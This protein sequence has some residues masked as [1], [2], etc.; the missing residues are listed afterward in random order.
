ML[1]RNCKINLWVTV[2][3]LITILAGP[4]QAQVEPDRSGLGQAEFRLSELD[5]DNEFRLPANLPDKAGPDAVNDLNVLGLSANAG[6]V[7]IR[8]GRWATLMMAEPLLP[9]SGKGNSL[10]WKNLGRKAPKNEAEL[11]REASQA[12]RG[13]IEAASDEFRIDVAELANPGKVTIHGDG[14]SIQIYV[15]R[16]FN[17]IPVRNSY[18]TATI[19]NG[20]MTIF[21]ANSWG[22]INISTVPTVSESDALEAVQSHAGSYTITGAWRSSELTLIPVAKG[23]NT[24]L[25]GVGD[26]YEYR[27]AWIIRPDFDGEMRHFE[28]LVDA[29]NGELLS[30]V[31]TNQYV[32]SQREVKGGVQPVSNDGV[33]P[34]GVEQAGWPMPFDSVSTPG[35]TVDTDSGGNLP[36]P[37]D[38][39]IT[40]SLSGP[41]V[42]INDNCGAISLTSTGD[43][44]F[45][46]SGGTDC[47][48]P[49][50][51]GAGNTHASRTGFHELNRIIEMGR[52][53]LPS[54]NWLQQ[55][56]T[57]NMNINQTCNAFWSGTV[58]F[59]RSGGGCAN[60]GELAGVFDH[61]WG[62]GL[63]DND[64]LPNIA[65]PSGEGIADVY[66]ALR[67]NTSCIGRNFLSGNCSG[68]GDPC[69][70]CSGVRDI[71]YLQRQSG[72]PHDYTWSNANCGGSVHC[73]G[74]VY[75]EAVWSLWKRNLQSAPYNTMTIPPMRSSPG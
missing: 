43:L 49:G 8:S 16:V 9:G 3:F 17:G 52:G 53:Q 68:N 33:V 46:T 70:D 63:D 21:G 22:D 57:S 11:S 20:N 6:M 45:G 28:A 2:L 59:Y 60:T 14:N 40:S 23:Q 5:I 38:G 62:H 10:S 66:T 25:I 37:V 1:I 34:D 15:P 69:L 42:N 24:N 64:A 50:S 26:G 13:F 4:L 71:D 56:L 67:L 30:F 44:D 51:G 19:N 75:S 31:D 47:V 32:A 48:T 55:Q 58:N 73:V 12:F 61:E 41:Y 39:N 35:G 72:Q 27:L 36:A 29:H 74:A 18:L 65:S 7:D 54:N